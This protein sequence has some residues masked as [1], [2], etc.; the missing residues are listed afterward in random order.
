MAEVIS[1]TLRSSYS[2][3]EIMQFMTHNSLR[4]YKKKGSN[5][6]FNRVIDYE[7]ALNSAPYSKGAIF[8]SPSKDD[9]IEGKGFIV[10]SY[11]GLEDSY[12]QLSHWTPNVY[13]GGTYYNF[14]KRVIKGHTRDNLKQINV[15]GFDIDTKNIDLYS[16]Y[17]GCEE[18]G[19]PRPNLL[20][21]TPRGFQVF[22]I[23]SSP[24]FIHKNQDYKSLRVAERLFSNIKKALSLF[25]PIDT[26][27]V[28]FGFFRIPKEENILDFFDE[29]ADTNKLLIWS[30]EFEKKENRN[31]LR[32]IYNDNNTTYEQTSATWYKSL[33]NATGIEKGHHSSSRNNVLFTLAIA[34]YSSGKPFEVAYDELDQFNSNLK[35]PLSKNEFERT[36]KSAYSGKYKGVKR[37]YVEPMLELW[38]DGTTNFQGGGGWY[39][40]KKTREERIRS[41]YEEWESDILT[42]LQHRT[43]PEAA[44]LEGSLSMLAETFGMAVSTLKEVLKRSKNIIKVTT[45]QG[46]GAI[47]KVA[48]RSMLIKR[49]LVLKKAKNNSKQLNFSEYFPEFNIE[50]WTSELLQQL[51]RVL[52]EIDITYRPGV[53]PPIQRS[54]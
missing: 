22:F 41:H 17:L 9:L 14:K 32:V 5:A 52:K 42:Y 26:G 54:S 45:G 15:I 43:N 3:I 53:S 7:K 39:K 11:E 4:L 48:S 51:D 16:L 8:V 24:F 49:L 6:P 28:P 27:C 21:E 13:R 30:K 37:S 33:I 47:T 2:P 40:F 34:N 19:L 18:L 36:I 44:F 23:L 46:R 20:L 50:I 38:T 12:K 29:P 1:N 10:T 25:V 31:L 35:A